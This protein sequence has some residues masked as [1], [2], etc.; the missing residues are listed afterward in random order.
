MKKNTILQGVCVDY[1]HDGAGIVKVDEFAFFVRGVIVGER[2]KFKVLK[3]KKTYG[4][5]KLLEIIEISSHRSKP[6]C[7]YYEKCGGCQLQHMD[8]EEQLRFK[9]QLVTNNIQYL[10]KLNI[11]VNPVLEGEQL[12]YRNKAQFPLTTKPSFA[13]GFYRLHSNDIIN[14]TKCPIQSDKI[15]QLYSYIKK[16]LNLH[17]FSI[18]LRHIL[19]KHAVATDQI[20]IVFVATKDIKN[21]MKEYVSQLVYDTGVTSVVLNINERKDNVILGNIEH[22]LYGPSTIQD[23]L[24]N[25]KFH[26][27][28]KSF[29]QVNPKQTKLLYEKALA[30]AEIDKNDKV[31]DL[32]CG[33]GTITLFFAKYAKQVIGIEIVEEA[34]KNA[35][36]NAKINKIDNVEF[37]CSDASAYVEKLQKEGNHP[38]I[39]VIDPPRKGC[40]NTTITNIV[41]MKPNRIVYVSCNPATLARDLQKFDQYSYKCTVVQPIDMFPSTYHVETVVLLSHKKIKEHVKLSCEPE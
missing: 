15:N 9:H 3:L 21:E 12:A 39:V 35:K 28:S 8:K 20:M 16:N 27:A 36:E 40:D 5:G 19:I 29:Y 23:Q 33:V 25:M 37:I 32:Y 38:D 14:I 2:I 17:T 31:I 13:M 7:E 1:I 6:F 22:I 11:N 10:G 41:E 4:F 26:I 18:A 24:C 34:I 30:Y